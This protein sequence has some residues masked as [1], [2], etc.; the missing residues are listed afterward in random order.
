MLDVV[1]ILIKY[2]Q[3]RDVFICEFIDVVKPAKAKLHQLYV[4]PF[5]KY[6]DSAFNKFN[7][8]EHCSELLPFTWVSQ[9]SNVHL[10]LLLY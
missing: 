3:R 7:A 4:D 8:Y 6:E 2:A 5:C 1:H 9:E 10:Y